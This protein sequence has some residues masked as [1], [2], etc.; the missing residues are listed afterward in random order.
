MSIMFCVAQVLSYNDFDELPVYNLL[1][2]VCGYIDYSIIMLILCQLSLWVSLVTCFH[3]A[4]VE[5]RST[6]HL[7]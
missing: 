2:A 5:F 7:H 3:V 1:H 6:M 4:G